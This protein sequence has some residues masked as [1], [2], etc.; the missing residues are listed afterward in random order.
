MHLPYSTTTG[1]RYQ[2]PNMPLNLT[3]VGLDLRG[4][5]ERDKS[6]GRLTRGRS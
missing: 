3:V 4:W 6:H 5:A 2:P 1:D